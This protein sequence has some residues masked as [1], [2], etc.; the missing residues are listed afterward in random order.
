[1]WDQ[2]QTL[3]SCQSEQKLLKLI[4]ELISSPG[5]RRQRL[6]SGG[7]L[8]ISLIEMN[9]ASVT[10]ERYPS[11]AVTRGWRRDRW[12]VTRVIITP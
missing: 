4:H 6:S 12:T 1:M 5:F 2:I 7:D 11:S 8:H 9:E 10:A 3:L